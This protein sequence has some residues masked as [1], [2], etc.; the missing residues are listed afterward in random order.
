MTRLTRIGVLF[1]LFPMALFAEPEVSVDQA[2]CLPM[3][4]H[5]V[6]TAQVVSLPPAAT[7]RIYF[8]RL[9]KDVDDFYYVV[10]RT[11]DG[12][13]YWGTLPKPKEHKLETPGRRRAHAKWWIDRE[14]SMDRGHRR[15]WLLVPDPETVKRQFEGFRQEPVEY[16]AALFDAAGELLTRTDIKV[17]P[18]RDD[19]EVTLTA[20]Q[21]GESE[22][23][24]IGETEAWQGKGETKVFHWECSG[25]VIR[26]DP[27]GVRRADVCRD[28]FIAQWEEE[29]WPEEK[30]LRGSDGEGERPYETV[31]VFY[32]TDRKWGIPG[33]KV[34]KFDRHSKAVAYG[35]ERGKLEFGT[36]SVSIPVTHRTGELEDKGWFEYKTDPARH[37]VL[38]TIDRKPRELFLSELKHRIACGPRIKDDDPSA[39]K[40][41]DK[42]IL[43][44]IH[45]YNVSFKDAA[46]RTAQIAYDLEF[47]G[48]PL[49]YSWPSQ[50]S[51]PG[52][53]ADEANIRWTVPHLEEFLT[54]V[55]ENA[56]ADSVHVIA[57]SMGNR[58]ITEVLRRFATE[59]AELGRPRLNQIVLVAP[60]VDAAVFRDEIAPAF[61]GVAERVTLYASA[62]DKALNV[63]KGLHQYPRAGDLSEEVMIAEGIE[64]IDASDVDTSLLRAIRLGH[65]YFADKASAIDDLKATL[66]GVEA[67]DRVRLLERCYPAKGGMY[68]KILGGETPCR[69]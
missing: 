54:L 43:V 6:I 13:N 50:A 38:L 12:G 36:L 41:G 39:C 9:N 62:H 17:V 57:H 37:V 59:R 65:S 68:W 64:T 14:V 34:W 49:M 52:Y 69:E 24:V 61:A 63:S 29:Q 33:E 51:I 35:V 67:N 21:K 46:R 60:D 42:A 10:A 31:E 15:N 2:E 28:R 19:C 58:A 22:N 32:G 44:F 7:T 4:A 5:G 1:W 16:Y 45:G 8:R 27:N 53:T 30:R 3:A 56:Q 40:P 48:V 20:Q 55:T 26:I 47:K 66:A 23:L 25:I 11:N 18:V